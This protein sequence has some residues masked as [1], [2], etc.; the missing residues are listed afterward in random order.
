MPFRYIQTPWKHE[1]IHVC[2]LA[3]ARPNSGSCL[4]WHELLLHDHIIYCRIEK[5]L[6]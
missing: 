2:R 4:G 3:I 5:D 6:T 1:D